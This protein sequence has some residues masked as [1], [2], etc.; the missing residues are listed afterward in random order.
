MYTIRQAGESDVMTIATQRIQMFRDNNL[1]AINTWSSLKSRSEQWIKDKLR[2]GTYIGW[3]AEKCDSNQAGL[4][5]SIVGG[6]GL[7]LM[8]WP[9]HYLHLEPVRGYLL[10]FYV[11]P[12]ARRQGIAKRLVHLAVTE[13]RKRKIRLAVLHAST[14]GRPVYES[15]GWD[16]SK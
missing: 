11:A 14:M 3:L 8:E 10:N 12:Q 15:L 4:E 6:A 13:C 5:N 9:P 16:V 1:K 7:W 2:E